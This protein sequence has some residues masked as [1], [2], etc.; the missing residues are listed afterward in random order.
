M[1][2]PTPYLAAHDPVSS[3]SRTGGRILVDQLLAQGCDRIFCVPGEMLSRRAR[4][5]ARFARD[6]SRR[7]P[8]GGRRRLYGGGRR[9]ADRP[10]R[11]LL[12]DARAGRDQ[13][14]DRRPHRDAGFDADDP[15]RRRRRAR[16]HATARASRRSIS[17]RC[18]RRSPN[19]RREIDDARAHPRICRARLCRRD[20]GPA[21]AGGAGAARGHAARR[22]RGDR[23]PA[24][25]AAAA[26][27]RS[28]RDRGADRPAARR[29]RPARDRRRRGLGCG[30]RR[31]ISPNSPKSLGLPVASAFRRQDAIV[32]RLAGLCGQSRL[33]PQSQAGRAREG[34]RPADRR[35]RAARRGDDRRLYADHARAS[36]ARRS[37]TSIPTRTNC[38]RVYRTDLAICADMPRVRRRARPWRARHRC[39][40][41][42]GAEAHAEWEAWSTPRRATASRSISARASRR[43]ARRCRPT[44]SSATAPAIMRAGG[45]AIWRYGPRGT[46][47]APTNG[48]MGY[49]VPAAIAAALRTPERRVVALAGD[50]CFLMNGQELATAVAHGAAPARHRRRQWRSTARSACIRSANI[51][52]AYPAPASPIPISRRSL[53]LMAAGPRRS[54]DR[55]LRPRA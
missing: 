35:R 25:R 55:R 18:S 9:Q 17:P 44:R 16:R 8:A 51:P 19:G 7:L 45:I 37:S 32:Q 15:V 54:S 13:R 43:C 20:V 12:R 36:A 52:V 42:D 26:G 48:S 24:R 14:R 47:L 53:A 22:G 2:A 28:A 50:G 29:R 30:R 40:F 10:P 23:S 21:R 46:Q 31:I 49:G 41:D 1:S 39:R 6:R 27:R 5:A 11:H 4:R 33:R 34:G 3:P 38:S